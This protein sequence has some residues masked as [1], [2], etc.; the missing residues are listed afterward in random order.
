MDMIP[1]ILS[2]QV[3]SYYW[4]FLAYACLR[5]MVIRARNIVKLNHILEYR[6]RDM[7]AI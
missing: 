6:T 2:A 5:T 7:R 3:A 1:V 4:L